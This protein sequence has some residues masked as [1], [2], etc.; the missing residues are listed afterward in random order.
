MPLLKLKNTSETDCNRSSSETAQ[1]NLV[2]LRSYEGYTYY[3]DLLAE[4]SD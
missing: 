3:F 4:I 2:K 1:Q